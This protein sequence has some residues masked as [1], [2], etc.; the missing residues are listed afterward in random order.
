MHNRKNEKKILLDV[1]LKSWTFFEKNYFFKLFFMI[2]ISFKMTDY[3]EKLEVSYKS[4][5][6]KEPA[7]SVDQKQPSRSV[8]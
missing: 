6:P 3:N 5:S 1:L 7:V 2:L 8:L 4:F